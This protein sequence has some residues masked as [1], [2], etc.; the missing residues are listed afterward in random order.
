MRNV[1]NVAGCPRKT[2]ISA[3]LD[4]IVSSLLP[5]L[6][7]HTSKG[8]YAKQAKTTKLQNNNNNPNPNITWA[9]H[10]I[11][12]RCQRRIGLSPSASSAPLVASI[13]QPVALCCVFY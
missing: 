8:K 3:L 12:G 6:F 2:S 7:Q 11:I 1:R 10:Y 13:R 9:N 4:S 5:A